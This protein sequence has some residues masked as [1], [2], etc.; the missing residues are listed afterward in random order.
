MRGTVALSLVFASTV[1]AQEYTRGVGI[2]PGDPK[3]NFA[4]TLRV[5][6]NTYRNI[7]LHRPA[8]HSSSY[9]YN[10]TAQ[11]VTDGIKESKLPLW[12]STSSSERGTFKKNERE[13]LLDHNWVTSVPLPGQTGWVQVSLGGGDVLPEVNRVDVV[14][15]VRSGSGQGWT[16]V[17]SGSDDGQAWTEL[18]R[19]SGSDR[20]PGTFRQ[21]IAWDRPVR[22]RNYRVELSSPAA[23]SWQVGDLNFFNGNRKQGFGGP[24]H[25]S[26]AWMS[27]SAGEEWVYVD[28][29]AVCTFDRVAL[30]WI[31]RAAAGALQVSDDAGTWKTI[32]PLPEGTALTDDI[33]LSQP[34]K[35][36]Y[37][38]VLLSKAASADGYILS[39]FEVYGRAGMT[40]QP[41]R[42][43]QQPDGFPSLSGGAWRLQRDSLVGATGEV[44]SKPGYQDAEWMVATVPGTVLTSYLNAGAVPDPNFGDNQLQISDSFF[45]ADFWYRNEFDAP[46]MTAGKRVWLKF[47]GVNWK[48]DV[49]LNGDKVGRV[50]GGFMRGRFDVTDR[51]R[52]GRR[53]A[54]AVRVEKNATPG[55]VKEKTYQ[56]PDKNGGA[57][58][59]DNPTY[60]A[61]IGWDWIPTVRGRDT[62][63]WDSVY[64]STTGDVT[65][66]DPFVTTTLPLPDTTRA[67][68]GI[69][70]S[71]L[72][73]SAAP[74]TGRLRG[75]FGDIAVD[76]PVTIEA[77]ARKTVKLDP[78]THPQ[79]RLANPN[80]W[81]PAGYGDA[82][83]YRV[84]LSFEADNRT[85]SDSTSFQAGV[86]Q[87]TYSEQGGA[88]RMWINGRR[89]I[90]RGG[91]WGFS[92][93]MLRYRGREYEAAIRYHRDMHLNMI[94]NWVG[95]IGEDAFYE[96]CDR[97]GVVVWQDFWLANPYDGP[98]P[99]DNA[100][101]MTNVKDVVSRIRNHPSIGLYCGRNE[102]YPPKPLEDGIR[103]VLADSHPGLHY[104]SSS[105]DDVVSGHGPYQ[106]QATKAYFAERATPKFHS[107]M[108][109]PN[110]VTMD[111]LRLMMPESA[112]WPQGAMWGIHD[113][114]LTGAQGGTSFLQRIEKSYGGA[115]SAQEWVTLAQFVNYEGYRAMF[116]AQS[117]NRMGLLI[118]MSHPAWPSFVW[119]TYDYY[120]EPTAAYF[121]VKKASEPLHIQWNPVTDSVE[122]VNYSAGAAQSLTAKA[123]LINMDGSTRWQ[124]TANVDSAED[125]MVAPIHME[126]AAD[127]SPTHFIRLQLSRGSELISEN[128]YW[129]GT[130][131]DNFRAL[132]ELPRVNVQT[133]THARKDGNR[134]L[135]TT[136][137][138]NTSAS[139][140]LL[141]RLK[142]VRDKSGDRILPALYSDNYVSLMPGE[143]RTI[144]TELR[145]A[146]TR[147][148]SP[149]MVVEGFNADQTAAK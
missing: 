149:R 13:W 36:R 80:L 146:D 90:P 131:E 75:R 109:M 140:A 43:A 78:S 61:S 91:N 142:A 115:S 21:T 81:W 68:I 105:A 135:L 55:S 19:I 139:P 18:G 22:N 1:M 134:W 11:L 119:Q 31:R 127:L 86:R 100:L 62:G 72:N 132:R 42:A 57:L 114:S 64:L 103:Q 106:A 92:E 116:E 111:S 58:G 44:L 99:D 71:L 65:I 96:A 60:H 49:F 110:I 46:S 104:I 50:E 124:K 98:D 143:R 125:S 56:N 45:Y 101:F 2:Y 145:G 67:D 117:K 141:V 69:E 95:Q 6:A 82:N 20:P 107:E 25:F 17:V 138:Q 39:E 133:T 9:D 48:A 53:N 126:Y 27:A 123:E 89:F 12:V 59:A 118:W 7:A 113:F 34:V 112:M 148:E 94:R 144:I 10:L 84:Q 108:G 79:L 63:I 85:V 47:D 3:E 147:G 129:R 26:S 136:D 40:V 74:V 128:F 130:E 14:A 87:F 30:Y 41:K 24:F 121:G 4:P 38:R 32:Q 83:L 33:K 28:L 102:G 66:E 8:Y 77:S 51:I 97:N 23:T 29:G 35:G 93:S 16:A 88:L 15:N 54:I 76:A 52:P 120:L 73:H 122:V 37:V 5:D 70:V 137:L